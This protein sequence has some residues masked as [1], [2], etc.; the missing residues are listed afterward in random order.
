MWVFLIKNYFANL[1]QPE[2]LIYGSVEDYSAPFF[3]FFPQKSVLITAKGIFLLL[4]L[5]FA[6]DYASINH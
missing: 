5:G 2:W 4:L 6:I 1:F 3:F